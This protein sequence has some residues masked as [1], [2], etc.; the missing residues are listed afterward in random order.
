MA[1]AKEA[2]PKAKPGSRYVAIR[3]LVSTHDGHLELEG[4]GTYTTRSAA[5]KAIFRD[6]VKII[7]YR[8]SMGEFDIEDI[9]K[10][11]ESRDTKLL[12]KFADM[13]SYDYDKDVGEIDII[14]PVK[15]MIA[16]I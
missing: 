10:A 16:G 7:K 5:R 1:I 4:L 8:C 6:M 14:K 9:G 13:L 3:S 11:L 2:A 15:Y 12:R